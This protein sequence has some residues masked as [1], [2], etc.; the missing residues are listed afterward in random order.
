[1][2]DCLLFSLNYAMVT[3]WHCK[4][5]L[6][7]WRIEPLEGWHC[8]IVCMVQ[9]DLLRPSIVRPIRDLEPYSR[10]TYQSFVWQIAGPKFKP[11]SPRMYYFSEV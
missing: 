4:T 10:E 2:A 8:N 11:L 9:S 5:M 7:K 1:M 6:R 3:I